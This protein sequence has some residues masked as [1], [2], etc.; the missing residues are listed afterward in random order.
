[1]NRYSITCENRR[2]TVKA[3]TA[4]DAAMIAARRWITRSKSSFVIGFS[5]T[6]TGDGLYQAYVSA[7]RYQCATSTGSAIKVQHVEATR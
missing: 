2:S 1:M 4:S 7:P 5:V 6:H 3:E